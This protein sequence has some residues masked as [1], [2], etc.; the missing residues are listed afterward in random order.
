MGKG[1]TIDFKRK[2]A[3]IF[4]SDRIIGCVVHAAA[5]VDQPGI[6]KHAS[7]D[8]LIV[9][10]ADRSVKTRTVQLSEAINSTNLKSKLTKDII[11]WSQ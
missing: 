10:E 4:S 7:G 8:L 6:I 11:K 5:T 1:K 3:S 2:P 9:G